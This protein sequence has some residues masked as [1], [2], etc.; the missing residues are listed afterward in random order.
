MKKILWPFL[1]LG[2]VAMGC[3]E[4]SAP[5]DGGT[6]GTAA[7]ENECAG[8]AD[9]TLCNDGA[10]LCEVGQ[11]VDAPVV[12][13]DEQCDDG[14]ECTVGSCVDNICE[15]IP[16]EDETECGN[17]GQ[18]TD[19]AC[20]VDGA[21]APITVSQTLDCVVALMPISVP[22]E[23][24]VAPQAE[25]TAGG[26]VDIATELMVTLDVSIAE[27]VLTIDPDAAVDVSSASF[28]V[29]AMGTDE[30]MITRGLQGLP[31]AIELTDSEGNPQSFVIEGGTTTSPVTIG[32]GANSLDFQI[33]VMDVLLT[34][35]PLLEELQLPGIMDCDLDKDPTA[36]FPVG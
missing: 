9:G 29:M 4:D 8:A 24:T 17:G 33:D 31:M 36:S 7:D 16:L 20:I 13:E 28:D 35:V 5:V 19:G 2:I 22:L 11:C 26:T 15:H 3:G 18:C 23:L 25:L 34:N 27:L 10:G 30:E 12:C 14:N 1:I 32:T 21:P 6:G